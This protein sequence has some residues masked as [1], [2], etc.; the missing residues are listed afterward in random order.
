MT[1][2]FNPYQAPATDE[3]EPAVQSSDSPL[4]RASREQRWLAAMIDGLLAVLVV[5][6]LEYK[7]GLFDKHSLETAFT[8]HEVLLWGAIGFAVWFAE[9]GYFL[10]TNSQTI[11]K[12]VVGIRIEDISGGRTALWKIVFLRYLPS[13]CVANIPTIGS[14]LL[15]VD[16]LFI[17]RKDQRCLHDH[18]AGTHVVRVR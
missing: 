18:L 9:H 13:T 12:R 6:P 8:F 16:I 10:A 1:S 4:R 3:L 11:G 15:L 14:A 17:F 5:A 7:F 2:P